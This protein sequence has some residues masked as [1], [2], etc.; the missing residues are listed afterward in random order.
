MIKLLTLIF[1]M[2]VLSTVVLA[3]QEPVEKPQTL[4]TLYPKEYKTIMNGAEANNCTDPVLLCILF[5]IRN[6]ENGREGL[7]F[8]VMHPRAKDQP[9]S[10][11][12]QAGWCASTVSKNY[13]RWLDSKE[14]IDFISFLGRRYCPVGAENDP[15]KLNKYWITN[16]RGF[17]ERN[18]R[19]H[20][21]NDNQAKYTWLTAQQ[22]EHDLGR[23]STKA[24][25]VQTSSNLHA[26]TTDK[27]TIKQDVPRPSDTRLDN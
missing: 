5:A 9:N 6:A 7:E 1:C 11:R 18:L 22:L 24:R 10:L 13:K 26:Q 19:V 8:G 2:L 21:Q 23:N 16:V 25:C 3:S 12:V 27:E 15:T 14:D 4:A 20:L 17:T